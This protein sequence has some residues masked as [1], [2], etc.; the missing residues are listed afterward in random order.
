MAAPRAGITRSVANDV[1][2]QGGDTSLKLSSISPS[3]SKLVGGGTATIKGFNFRHNTDGTSPAV[4]IDGIPG[5]NVVIVDG[6]TLTFT[7]P[8]GTEQ[9]SF[10]VVVSIGT[11]SATLFS[12]FSYTGE[13]LQSISPSY[14]PIAGGTSVTIHGINFDTNVNYRVVFG[15]QQATNVVVKDSRTITCLTPA[16]SKGFKDVILM[17]PA[18]LF[19]PGI[20]SHTIFDV[21]LQS[22]VT[23]DTL[24]SAFQYTLLIRGEDIRRTPGIAVSMQLGA[25]PSTCQFTIDGDSNAPVGGEKIEITDSQDSNRLLWAGTIQT[26]QQ[27]YEGQTNQLAWQVSCVDFTW[28]ANRKRPVGSWFQV[29]VTQ[30]V[31]ELIQQCCPGFTINHVQTNLGKVTIVL[32]GSLDLITVLNTLAAAIGGGHWYFDFQQDLHFFHVQ[33]DNVASLLPPD[34]PTASTVDSGSFLTLAQGPSSGSLISYTKGYFSLRMQDVYSDGTVSA[35]KAWSN[36]VYFDGTKMFRLTNIP[37]G[38]SRGGLTVVARKIWYHRLGVDTSDSIWKVYPF[39]QINDNTTGAFDTLFGAT[40]ATS[41]AVVPFGS[42]G[43]PSTPTVVLGPAWPMSS[44]HTPYIYVPFIFQVS[45]FDASGHES[46][47]SDPAIL[48]DNDSTHGWT[49]TVPLGPAG[50]SKRRLY[51]SVASIT[52]YIEIPDNTTTTVQN[53]SDTGF[54]AFSNVALELVG[55]PGAT[56]GAG[57]IPTSLQPDGAINTNTPAGPVN[58][59]TVNLSSQLNGDPLVWCGSWTSF[60]TAFLYRDGSLSLAS[61]TSTPVGTNF[62]T[63]GFMGC[64]ARVSLETGPTI[65]TNNDC[66]ARF[67][68]M[69]QGLPKVQ[70]YSESRSGSGFP[71][72]YGQGIPGFQL[73]DPTWAQPGRGFT[74][75]PDNTTG[76]AHAGM[77]GWTLGNEVFDPA[78]SPYFSTIS[79]WAND[80]TLDGNGIPLG[81][82]VC[83]GELAPNISQGETGFQFSPDPIPVWP[84]DD[85]PY[86]EDNDSTPHDVTDS[87]T[88]LLHEDSQS[89]GVQVTTDF[90]QVRNRIFVIGSGSTLTKAYTGGL[91]LYVAD[92]SNFALAGGRFRIEDPANGN[93]EFAKYSTLQ[94]QNGTPY[95]LLDAALSNQYGVNSIIYNYFQ[96]DDKDSQAFLAKYELDAF[97]RPTDGIH[98]YTIT[99]GTLKTVWQLYMRAQ[100]ELEIYSKPII[101]VDYATRDPN[102][103]IGKTV[104][105]DLTNPP[106]KGSFLIQ[107][108]GID[109]I[110]DEGDQLAPR[111]TVKASS[112]RY[113][114]D[115]LLLRILNAASGNSVSVGG[116]ANAGLAAATGSAASATSFPGPQACYCFIQSSTLTTPLQIGAVGT[117]ASNGGSGGSLNQA[118]VVTE[119]QPYSDK[120]KGGLAPTQW[121]TLL[122]T[123]STNLSYL[124]MQAGCYLED[125][126]DLWFE[127]RTPT[128]VF[129]NTG[130]N[131]GLFTNGVP[132][133]SQFGSNIAAAT[134]RYYAGVDSGWSATVQNELSGANRQKA[135]PTNIPFLTGTTYILRIQSGMSGYDY[136]TVYLKYTLNGVTFQLNF[137]D[138]AVAQG[139]PPTIEMAMPTAGS[140]QTNGNAKLEPAICVFNQNG[141][142]NNQL[143]VKRIYMTWGR[144]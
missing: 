78:N 1:F 99:D 76:A 75:V 95:I 71:I 135:I 67:I 68:Y 118:D 28:L 89:Q 26:I 48:R 73:D 8:T 24:V 101:T 21:V 41:A 65:G 27:I 19:A 47:A 116:V 22:D 45:N 110:R 94:Q 126:I 12:A 83:P 57:T 55:T 77:A 139:A 131:I 141:T 74:V 137:A 15:D 53:S 125:L 5:T 84:N 115:D 23:F 64:T 63:L 9:G 127:F 132:T 114:L 44:S 88:D 69:C 70:G 122:A 134:L 144:Y 138:T 31:T 61:P 16:N 143:H 140:A 29:S 7:I 92:V 2:I 30:I 123:G 13:K 113:G 56:T 20:F 36:L 111:Y 109:Q 98:E 93:S 97:G 87:D 120:W 136:R 130:I 33:P 43:K 100:A 32:D 72:G 66:I 60:R 106:V 102:S 18:H 17:N 54:V 79:P 39:C 104:V 107:S 42:D 46:I 52:N 133:S 38:P 62:M 85:G 129:A 58:V 34:F 91:Q 4:T 6:N 40:G 108:V 96:A 119:F 103:R 128:R 35:L 124:A 25:P 37:T 11:I 14:G 82:Y 51:L 50:T 80:L 112:T 3:T 49:V 10:D 81:T 86:L 121:G 90:S 142:F 105:F 59:P 117:T